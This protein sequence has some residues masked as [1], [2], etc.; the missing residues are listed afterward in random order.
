[1]EAEAAQ[2][3]RRA[4][5][6]GRLNRGC[7]GAGTAPLRVRSLLPMTRARARERE[8][9]GQSG[10]TTVLPTRHPQFSL[11]QNPPGGNA[12]CAGRQTTGLR[13]WPAKGAARLLIP[14]RSSEPTSERRSLA[15]LQPRASRPPTRREQGNRLRSGSWRP[16]S[17]PMGSRLK[18]PLWMPRLRWQSRGCQA[19]Q[20]PRGPSRFTSRRG[21]Q[22]AGCS[23][24]S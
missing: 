4:S 18:Q 3:A 20:S 21:N 11:A 16:P 1:M 22:Q 15:M 12:R 19:G 7:A 17:A 13:G 8:V 9:Q 14:F 6:R 24:R 2:D 23:A 5:L 10:T